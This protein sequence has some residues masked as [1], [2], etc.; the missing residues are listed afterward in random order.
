[1]RPIYASKLT[2]LLEVSLRGKDIQGFQA[3]RDHSESV[4]T[5]DLIVILS[6]DKEKALAHIQRAKELGAGGM[7]VSENLAER[8]PNLLSDSPHFSVPSP[9]QAIETII[10]HYFPQTPSFMAAVTGTNGKTSVTTFARQLWTKLGT[11]AASL[12]TLGVFQ[13]EQPFVDAPWGSLTTPARLPMCQTLHMLSESGVTHSILEASSHGLHQGRL[14]GLKFKVGVFTNFSQD[15]LDYHTN[16]DAYWKAKEVLFTHHLTPE[17]TAILYDEL[18]HLS[19]LRE[20]L[21]KRNQR[22]ITYGH[23]S[24]STLWVKRATPHPQGQD[25]TLVFNG[26]SVTFFFPLIGRIQL[27]NALA[28]AL[29]VYI[30]GGGFNDIIRALSQLKSVPGRMQYIGE[31]PNKGQVFV[32][33]A[34][35][36]DAL[37]CAL[38]SLRPHTPGQ[39]H[40]LFGCGGG[41]DT[42]K[43]P[44]MG[45]IAQTYAD[46]PLITDDN[47]RDEDPVSIRQHILKN[48]SQ[49][50]DAGPRPQAIKCAIS[51]LK[52]GDALLI[53]GKGHEMDQI[54]QNNQRIPHNDVKIAKDVIKY[55]ASH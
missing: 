6:A 39:L 51:S 43:R 53:A 28:A 3:I 9:V 32:D 19:E 52:A 54:L 40:V 48:C 8:Y 14:Q 11:P 27:H 7:I 12:G 46:Y 26:K 18:P 44:I 23:Q 30:S 22:I 21:E 29:T 55:L 33:Y 36:P 5:G 34:H 37:R 2:Q 41:R 50:Q 42:S 35:T 10:K 17:G 38:S 45:R 13:G 4:K 25:V 16:M 15:H 47:P 24:G 49:G 20:Y 31:T 1:V